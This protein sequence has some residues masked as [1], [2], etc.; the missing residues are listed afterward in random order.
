MPVLALLQ[1]PMRIA[2]LALAGQE[3]QGVA[4]RAGR[5]WAVPRNLVAGGNDRIEHAAF[6][7]LPFG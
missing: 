2:D 3:D 5:S 7:V 4:R 6:A 1:R